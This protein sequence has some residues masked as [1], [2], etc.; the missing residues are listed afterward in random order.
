MNPYVH[1]T[2]SLQTDD[3]KTVVTGQ[4]IH[5]PRAIGTPEDVQVLKAM[6]WERIQVSLRQSGREDDIPRIKKVILQGW[7][8]LEEAE[9]AD[10]ARDDAA[11]T[12]PVGEM[13][14][15]LD[16]EDDL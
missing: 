4:T 16:M 15:A 8:R 12:S 3:A 11:G 14:R 10:E 1:V 2:L 13:D 9:D 5:F 7:C 6:G